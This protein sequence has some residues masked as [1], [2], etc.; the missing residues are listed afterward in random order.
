MV[1]KI[2]FNNVVPKDRLEHLVGLE[3]IEC[4]RRSVNSMYDSIHEYNSQ[5][6]ESTFMEYKY[7]GR[8][9]VNIFETVEFPESLNDKDLFLAHLRRKLKIVGTLTGRAFRPEMKNEPQLNF[10]DDL[11]DALLL[12]WVSGEMKIS[13]N[14]Y[15]PF[16]RMAPSF[17]YMLIRFGTPT[18]V[19]LRAGYT[20]HKKFL[21]A[22]KVL[23]QQN[24]SDLLN[25]TWLPVTKVT[26]AEAEEISRILEAGLLESEVI[27]EGCIGRLA[28]CAAP[29]ID[30]LK[31]QKQ[32]TDMMA[33][34]QYLAQVFHVPYTETDTGYTTKV[35]FKINHKGGF[36]FKSKVNERIIRRILDVFIEVRYTKD[37]KGEE[38]E[39]V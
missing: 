19:E 27:G 20:S 22:L 4:D 3:G 25:I 14:G 12:Q 9:A 30:D 26:E 16:E 10:I 7:A 8:T 32:Y 11:G 28:V 33:G 23:M 35:K 39:A 13:W 29:G 37:L 2:E 34:R 5:I 38:Q 18:Y 36:E 6:I 17:Q 21:E 15:E 1:S 31:K 24:D